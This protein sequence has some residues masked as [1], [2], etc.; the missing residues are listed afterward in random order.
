MYTISADT[1]SYKEPVVK[2][3]HI[4][5]EVVGVSAPAV[6]AICRYSQR[7]SFVLPYVAQCTLPQEVDA[8]GLAH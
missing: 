4:A 3:A 7:F 5:V 2:F 8:P 6:S 1:L